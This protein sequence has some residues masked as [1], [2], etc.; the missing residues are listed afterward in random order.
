VELVYSRDKDAKV[1]FKIH[2]A[3]KGYNEHLIEASK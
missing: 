1:E 3:G 2:D